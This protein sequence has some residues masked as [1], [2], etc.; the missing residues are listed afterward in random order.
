MTTHPTPKSPS[1]KPQAPKPWYRQFWPWFIIALPATVVVAGIAMVFIAFKHADTLVNDQYY[2]DGLAINEVLAE[3]L[4]AA[5]LG[6]SADVVFDT[7]S[8]EVLINLEGDSNGQGL[9]LLLIHPVEERHDQNI[10]L[11]PLGDGRFRADLEV[12][13]S[14]RFYVRLQGSPEEGWRLNGELDFAVA[15]Q[16][17]MSPDA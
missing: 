6:M 5:E 10:A 1:P 13:P 2:K 17:H 14:H 11:I 7:L 16:L 12:I 4:R 8:G 9:H 3:D 15:H